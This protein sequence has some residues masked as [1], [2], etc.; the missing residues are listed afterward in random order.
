MPHRHQ[1]HAAN[2]KALG[3]YLLEEDHDRL[4]AA[5]DFLGLT[6]TDFVCN[7]IRGAL[8]E[9]DLPM[10]NELQHIFAGKPISKSPRK[11]PTPQKSLQAKKVTAKRKRTQNPLL[12]RVQ[13]RVLS[14][15]F[16][17]KGLFL[18]RLCPDYDGDRPAV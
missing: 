18:N 16:L 7:V 15:V 17:S 10:F 9:S 14:P 4:L 3:C 6:K 13:V 2:K 5:S 1:R 11:R 8:G 12:D